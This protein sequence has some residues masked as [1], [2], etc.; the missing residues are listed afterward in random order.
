MSLKPAS[1]IRVTVSPPNLAMMSMT[2]GPPACILTG[3]EDLLAMSPFQP[4]LFALGSESW[5][6]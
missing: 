5:L 2:N 6:N 4:G 1:V 3:D